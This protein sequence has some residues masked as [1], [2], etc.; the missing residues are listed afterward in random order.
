MSEKVEKKSAKS[1]QKAAKKLNRI[2]KYFKD[3]ISEG[4]K[5][6]WPTP[7]QVFN[8]TLVVIVCIII[9]GLIIWGVDALLALILN[10]LLKNA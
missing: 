3:L 7:K 4:K 6:S 1:T 10:L 9:V 8:N 5:I 2:L